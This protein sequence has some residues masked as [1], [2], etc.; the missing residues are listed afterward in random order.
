M[1]ISTRVDLARR[2]RYAEASGLVTDADVAA[3]GASMD[4]PSYDLTF[5]VIVDARGIDEVEVS[6]IALRRLAELM[7]RVDQARLAPGAW[8]RV[9]IVAASA[10]VFGLARMYQSYREAQQSR[11]AY[12]VCRTM[13]EAHRWLGLD[14]E[15]SNMSGSTVRREGATATRP[16]AV[17]FRD[18]AGVRWYVVPRLLGRGPDAV[19]AGFEFTSE[20]GERRFL[21]WEPREFFSPREVD[22]DQW[23]YLLQTA[24]VET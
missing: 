22:E 7:Q 8:P 21:R 19:P 11:R 20:I 17:V 13:E 2:V 3:Y 4:D 15:G 23:R 14:D 16:V 12:F 24:S 6:T 9:A 5:D 18:P 10:A 1:P